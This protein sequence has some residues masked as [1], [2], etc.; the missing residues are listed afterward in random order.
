M[1]KT[2]QIYWFRC[3]FQ[4]SIGL[5]D[6]CDT[7]EKSLEL[8]KTSESSIFQLNSVVSNSLLLFNFNSL[9][10]QGQFQV[11]LCQSCGLKHS[12]L[13]SFFKKCAL[14][15]KVNQ[16]DVLLKSLGE[17]LDGSSAISRECETVQRTVSIDILVKAKTKES[18]L[19]LDGFGR[20]I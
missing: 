6:P 9:Q 7:I 15:R 4:D 16:L 10:F 1:Y 5:V 11:D 14:A 13:P 2:C 18:E 8:F 3:V 12:L 20:S 19:E 17:N